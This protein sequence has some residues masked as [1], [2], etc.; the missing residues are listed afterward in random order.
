MKKQ[1]FVLAAALGLSTVAVAQETETYKPAQGAQSLEV[2]FDPGAIF[3]SNN[4]GIFALQGLGSQNL[5]QG[6][7]YRT[8]KKSDV[9]AYRVTALVG[10]DGINQSTETQ[11]ASGDDV[12]LK[13]NQS[14]WAIQIRPG[15]EKHF[16]GT[17]RLSPYVG[18]EAILGFGANSLKTDELSIVNGDDIETITVK[19]D[20]TNANNFLPGFTLGAGGIAGF[21]YYV[22]KDLYLGLEINYA[23]TFTQVGKVK[24]ESTYEGSE[25]TEVEGPSLTSFAPR[26][27]AQF[28]LGWNF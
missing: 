24:T 10:F 21:D 18:L 7:K 14:E 4:N 22:A 16:G 2:T 27:T 20:I 17:K 12:F 5:N 9:L 11:N 3:G 1:L 13:T 26:A 8:F 28:K 6:V 25:T 15:F 19:N 23:F